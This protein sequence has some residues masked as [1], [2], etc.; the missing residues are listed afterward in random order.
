M[1]NS[2]SS[3]I[4]DR[5]VTNSRG[6]VQDF[7]QQE[8]R[9]FIRFNELKA[10]GG[11]LYPASIGFPNFSTNRE[12]FSE[13]EDVL[14]ANYPN[15]LNWGIAAFRIEDIPGDISTSEETTYSFVPLH[16]PEPYNYSHTEMRTEK[17][18]I[19]Q[20]GVKI[21][22]SKV[23]REFRYKLSEKINIIK[24]VEPNQDK[25]NI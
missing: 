10:V 25:S 7:S 17:N 22:S 18:G 13:P 1:S 19:Y 4:P 6:A 21:K 8:E 5:L 15:Y 16:D 11:N 2:D 24:Q 9:L 23:K 3:H 12:R 14:L 20:E